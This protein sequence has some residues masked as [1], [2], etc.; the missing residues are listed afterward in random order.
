MMSNL[1]YKTINYQLITLIAEAVDAI[2]TYSHTA[3]QLLRR[4]K[5]KRE[6]I[7]QYLAENGMI[8]PV[9]S[10]KPSLIRKAMLYWGSPQQVSC[11]FLCVSSGYH[12]L[13]KSSKIDLILKQ[14]GQGRKGGGETH[15]V[16]ELQY[17][18]PVHSPC[19][20]LYPS[21]GQNSQQKTTNPMVDFHWLQRY[22]QQ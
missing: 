9:T 6:H 14:I 20:L 21:Y 13:T 12:W 10:D 18:A 5:V 19:S 16:L 22:K 2:V 8:E 17:S 4:K 3:S 1:K 7:Y 15:V 11:T